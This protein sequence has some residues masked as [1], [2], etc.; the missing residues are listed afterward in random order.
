MHNFVKIAA[1]LLDLL[2]KDQ[3]VKFD[4]SCSEVFDILKNKLMNDVLLKF[5]NFETALKNPSQHM[6]ILDACKVEY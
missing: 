2:K 6:I 1:P 4:R 3:K 5:P